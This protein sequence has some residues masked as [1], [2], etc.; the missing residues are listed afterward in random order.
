MGVRAGVPPE[1][2]LG[3]AVGDMLGLW[4][5][6]TLF[7]EGARIPTDNNQAERGPRS[8][9]VGRENHY[10]SRSRRQTEVAAL[11]RFRTTSTTDRFGTTA[12]GAR[13]DGIRRG[14]MF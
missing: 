1:S 11:P 2:S 14:V 12:H 10:G 9:V 8:V 6:L 5:G 3:K 4:N 7:L 13:S